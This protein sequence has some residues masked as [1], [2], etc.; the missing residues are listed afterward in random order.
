PR[1]HRTQRAA[2]TVAGCPPLLAR[3]RSRSAPAKH[4]QRRQLPASLPAGPY[5][6][7]P[8]RAHW[9]PE[10]PASSIIAPETLHGGLPIGGDPITHQHFLDGEEQDLDIQPQ[11]AVVNVPDIQ[12]ELIFPA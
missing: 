4:R 10:S 5:R 11:G 8:C 1:P 9:R 12:L 3:R 2:L 7:P 6:Q